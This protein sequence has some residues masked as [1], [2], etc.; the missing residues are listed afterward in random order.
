MGWKIG[1]LIGILAFAC[2]C[3]KPPAKPVVSQP[4]DESKR[5]PLRVLLVDASALEKSLL[6]RWQGVSQQP[7]E[8]TTIDVPTFLGNKELKADVLIYPSAVLA[9]SIERKW[10]SP[11]PAKFTELRSDDE[12]KPLR[13]PDAWHTFA[14]YGK[15]DWSVPLSFHTCMVLR[16][17]E[18]EKRSSWTLGELHETSALLNEP[19][20]GEGQLDLVDR[21]LACVSL[22]LQIAPNS[23]PLFQLRNMKPRIAEAAFV[24]GAK[25]WLE[26]AQ[27]SPRLWTMSH[28]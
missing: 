28:E 1:I 8:F 17:G 12:S 11:L 24:E 23:S 25:V 16:A 20:E 19:M 26:A 2:G 5:P 6:V 10:L 15:R 7:I 18:K 27:R 21:Y 3:P 22:Q 13:W 4:V 9:E 14:S